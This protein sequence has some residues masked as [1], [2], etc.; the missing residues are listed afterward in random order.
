MAKQLKN[1]LWITLHSLAIVVTFTS[2]LTGL[3]ISTLSKSSIGH[4][5][6]LLPQGQVHSVHFFSAVV[7]SAIFF[8]YLFYKSTSKLQSPHKKRAY[9]KASARYHRTIT[10]AG[11]LCIACI[12]ASG[13]MLFV[14]NDYISTARQIHFLAALGVLLYIFLHAGVYLSTYGLKI[15]GYLL[16]KIRTGYRIPVICYLSIVSITALLWLLITNNSHH[17][18]TAKKIDPDFF[19]TID[20]LAQES[21][22]SHASPLEIYTDGGANFIDGSSTISLKAAYNQKEIFFHITWEDPTESLKHLPLKKVDSGWEIQ[23]Q[24]FQN[25]NETRYYEDKFAMLLSNSCEFGA[26]ST[27]HL[28]RKPL[29]QLPANWHGK[30]YHYSS[31]EQ[32]HDLWH[33]KA[34]RTNKMHLA[35]DNY[36]GKP[37]IVRPGARRYTAGYLQD[38]KESGAYL[39]NWQWYSPNKVTPK[40]LPKQASSLTSYQ[41]AD[42]NSDWTIAWFEY[43][44]YQ[45]KEDTY[46]SNTTMPSVLYTSNR[47]EGDRADVRARAIW[48]DGYWS[49]EVVRKLD[50]GST[51]DIPVKDGICLWVSAFDHSQIAHTRHAQPIKLRLAEQ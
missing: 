34:V 15:L 40:R 22:W 39:M 25:F 32:I 7:V 26:S 23:Q 48:Q 49:M 35:D 14:G 27:S 9:R 42:S 2:L 6:E 45:R 51:L 13:W 19:I 50:T 11:T 18:L 33:W 37:D 30:G 16:P 10:R 31:S 4:I 46:P 8:C 12:V 47:F 38:G 3:R 21:I 28:G 24:G 29:A 5:E 43:Q 41:H 20:G 44:P 17:R 1:T 36:I